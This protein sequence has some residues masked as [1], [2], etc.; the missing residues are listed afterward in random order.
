MQPWSQPE[1][2]DQRKSQA[3]EET[4]EGSLGRARETRRTVFMEEG[5]SN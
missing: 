4:G 2:R 5:V 1:F 3:A